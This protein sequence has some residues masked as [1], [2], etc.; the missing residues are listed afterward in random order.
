[1]SDETYNG[2]ANY[3]TW[4]LALH[5]NNDEGLQDAAYEVAARAV[6]GEGVASG[7][8]AELAG[9]EIVEW[10][11]EVPETFG[12]V[13]MHG[14]ATLPKWYVSLLADVGSFWRVDVQEIGE[15]FLEE[16]PYIDGGSDDAIV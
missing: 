12:Y 15:A 8:A 2:W 4:A 16:N 6:E 11:R 9:R 5:L 1:M 3:E 14:A 10:I 13:D 7:Y